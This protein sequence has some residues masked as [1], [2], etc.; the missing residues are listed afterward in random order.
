MLPDFSTAFLA[1]GAVSIMAPLL[2]LTM[3]RDAG[4]ELSGHHV[5]RHK[6]PDEAESEAR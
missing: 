1:V 5:R 4:A 6:R 2:S 3:R